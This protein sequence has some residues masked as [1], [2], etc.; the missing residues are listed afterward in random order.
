MNT[1]D[2]IDQCHMAFGFQTYRYTRQ[3]FPQDLGCTSHLHTVTIQGPDAQGRRGHPEV[4]SFL[5]GPLRWKGYCTDFKESARQVLSIQNVLVN[6]FPGAEGRPLFAN[7][8]CNESHFHAQC[9]HPEVS[10][11]G[12]LPT[13]PFSKN[14]PYITQR[15]WE[16]LHRT[17]PR[18]FI[19]WKG[20]SFWQK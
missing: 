20:N 1:D 15:R 13:S 5:G 2:Y 9:G 18:R 11:P 8:L 16:I 4:V 10:Q 19:G 3:W 12:S 17:S 6:R 14:S 7:T